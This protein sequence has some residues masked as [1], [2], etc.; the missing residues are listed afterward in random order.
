MVMNTDIQRNNNIT[1]AE[2]SWI[3]SRWGRYP[4]CN[5][6]GST[7]APPGNWTA[8]DYQPSQHSNRP[9]PAPSLA[10]S[11]ARIFLAK[12]TEQFWDEGCAYSVMIDR[13]NIETVL[14]PYK[15][16]EYDYKMSFEYIETHPQYVR[17]ATAGVEE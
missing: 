6:G 14:A 17:T 7:D 13:C 11:G 8:I 15:C 9:A 10:L 5:N 16:F 12:P 2:T 1:H 4:H 3:L